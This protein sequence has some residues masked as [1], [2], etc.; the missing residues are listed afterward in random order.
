MNASH[1]T[2]LELTAPEV[3]QHTSTAIDP[4]GPMKAAIEAVAA[5]DQ[6]KLQAFLLTFRAMELPNL[7]ERMLFDSIAIKRDEFAAFVESKIDTDLL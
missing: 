3:P 1:N 6:A 7:S 5:S 4:L 2:T